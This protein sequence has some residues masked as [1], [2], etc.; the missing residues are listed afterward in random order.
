MA[1]TKPPR[2]RA[3]RRVFP[4]SR[5][6]GTITTKL[7][8]ADATVA[9]YA[10]CGAI[11]FFDSVPGF[12]ANSP[13]FFNRLEAALAET[14]DRYPHY[15][16]QLQWASEEVVK[17]DDNPRYLG[18]PVVTYGTAED[19]GVE[20]VIVEDDRDLNTLVPSLEERSTSKRV[21]KASGL[22]QAEFLPSTNLAFFSLAKYQGLPGAAAQLT[23]FKCGGFAVSLKITH[24]LSDATCLLNFVH[25]WAKRSRFLFD[26]ERNDIHGLEDPA[27]TFDPRGLDAYAKLATGSS[28]IDAE[29]IR[30]A[31][32]L[33]MHRFSWWD[34]DAPGYPSWAT[35]S[36]KATMPPAEELTQIQLS[37]STYPPWPTWNLGAAVEHVQIRFTAAE[38][39]LIKAAAV[40]TLPEGLRTQQISR[41]DAMIAYIWILIN[42][43]RQVENLRDEV[44][45]DITLGMR[46]RLSPP[47]PDSFIGSPIVMAYVSKPGTEVA[48]ATIG[49]VAGAIRDMVSKFTP[50]AL[51]DYLYDAAQEV[52]PQRLWQGFLGSRHVMVTSWVRAR[53]YEVDFCGTQNLARYVQS[54]MPLM[55][56]LL[57]LMDIADTGD[58]DISLALEKD[59]MQRLLNDPM[60]SAYM[61]S[62]V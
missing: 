2:V 25:S 54:H 62:R 10:P 12:N 46:N 44:F 55:D 52:S 36:S 59:A 26:A 48:T 42:R 51:S 45:I 50:Q 22:S 17:G 61:T 40:E 7:S 24:C 21:W 9:R 20:L 38:V 33:P 49:L 41:Q 8:I 15:V 18:R 53:A 58:F 37:P 5:P 29:R 39:A 32:S 19:P 3:V 47:L 60:L 11:W 35:A 34:V 28:E 4:T 1:E 27:G 30:H 23:A 6:A 14:L 13:S 56:G 57:Q 43:A 31:R 16:G